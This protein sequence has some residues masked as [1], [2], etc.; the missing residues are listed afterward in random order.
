MIY[1]CGFII[2][3]TQDYLI[4]DSCINLNY[5]YEMFRDTP[6][7]KISLGTLSDLKEIRHLLNGQLSSELFNLLTENFMAI[8]FVQN[9]DFNKIIHFCCLLW[10]LFNGKKKLVDDAYPYNPEHPGLNQ[11][12]EGK[13][14]IRTGIVELRIVNSFFYGDRPLFIRALQEICTH[15]K[16]EDFMYDQFTS[17]WLSIEEI[18]YGSYIKTLMTNAGF[19][20]DESDSKNAIDNLTFF[21]NGYRDAILDCD[22]LMYWNFLNSYSLNTLN[23]KK[24]TRPLEFFKYNENE[25]YDFLNHKAIL[26]LTPFKQKIEKLYNSGNI[27]RLRKNNRNLEDIDLVVLEGFL[28]TY[29]NK[30]HKDF[31]HTFRYY[32]DLIDHQIS[33]KKFDVFTCSA[34]CYGILLCNYVHKK[35]N[36]TCLYIGHIMNYIF[37]IGSKTDK[38]SSEYYE[39]SDL[40]NRYTNIEKIEDNR[41]GS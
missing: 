4:D 39:N 20:F 33:Q 24:Q 3:N 2:D 7:S 26:F 22:Y 34:G 41:Y 12:Y 40:N 11:N 5:F 36:I 16:N 19:Y 21:A 35:H 13:L 17:N 14:L 10:L 25:I 31:I 28:T 32:C 1:H 23:Q 9:Y 18:N 15:Y 29:P 38:G 27:Y 8:G 6:V 30:K 37:G